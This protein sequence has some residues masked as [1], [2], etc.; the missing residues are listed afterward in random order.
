[1]EVPLFY[2]CIK[3]LYITLPFIVILNATLI[4]DTWSS[5]IILLFY[6]KL[7]RQL[8]KM[9]PVKKNPKNISFSYVI[10]VYLCSTIL[11]QPNSITTLE[12]IN[13]KAD[14]NINNIVVA[15]DISTASV[16]Q[17][18]EGAPK[19]G[20]PAD[21]SSPHKYLV[22]AANGQ[23]KVWTISVTLTK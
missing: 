3:V 17:P 19:L 13:Q 9:Q 20:V 22:K 7:V 2:I 15:V 5:S 6:L 18:V 8:L 12:I 23:T 10:Y 16:M 1:M 21:W 4:Y 11:R 14:V